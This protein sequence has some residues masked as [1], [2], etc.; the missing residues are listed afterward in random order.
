MPMIHT[1]FPTSPGPRA[2]RRWAGRVVAA[3]LGVALLPALALPAAATT[4]TD[5]AAAVTT[6]A[7]QAVAWGACKDRQLKR[8]G[9]QCAKVRV[10]LDYD[11]PAGRTIEIAVSRVKA[12]GD[13]RGILLANPGGPGGVGLGFAAHL[14]ATLKG[15]AGRYDLIGFDP[16]FLG[17]S[18]P[19]TCGKTAPK[20]E[21]PRTTSPRR[22]FEESLRAARD[23]A[24]RCL[25][26]GGNR[27][28]LPHATTNNVARD[29]DTIRAALGERKLS[30]FGV[31]YGADLGAVFTQL[32][33]G[34]VDRMVIDSSSDPRATQ[35]ELFRQSGGPLERAL[36]QWA[37]WAAARHDRYR[38]GRTGAAVRAAVRRLVERAERRPPVVDGVR[39]DAAVL[40]LLLRQLVQHREQD[41]ALAGVVR[42]LVNRPVRPGPHLRA[43][44]DLLR[45]PDLAGS[46][47]GATFFMCGDA[48][49]PAGGWPDD[50]ETYW[51]NMRQSRA[52]QPVFGPL[53]NGMMAPCAYWEVGSREPV[54]AIGNAVPVL[55]LQAR[56][57]NLGGALVLHRRLRGSRLLTAEIRAHGVYGRGADGGSP[58]PCADRAVNAYLGG[59]EL[60]GKDFTCRP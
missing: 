20:P 12:T 41:E 51:R 15:V 56:S 10:P 50:P 34:R 17:E 59:G 1:S 14:R 58:L 27:E 45:S 53:V 54:T 32:F 39:L 24:R 4:T 30:F 5:Q 38:L 52:A 8:A 31:S 60:P 47:L 40:R 35:Y 44:L 13:R 19:I 37:R 46:M 11:D 2:G 49:W 3:G 42:D 6:T 25:D 48:G 22:E 21:P 43:M 57:D 33:P 28:L 9:A 36:D 23:T 29:M 26:K 55:M 7:D 18:T 16:R